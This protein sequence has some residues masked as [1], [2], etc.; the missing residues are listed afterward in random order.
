MT[1][2]RDLPL[3]RLQFYATAAYTCS[4]LP[5]QEARSQVV[6]PG[7]LVDQILYSHLVENGFR[8][9]GSFTYR[10]HCDHCRACTPVRV[11]VAGFK[12]NRSQRRTW[13][14]HQHLTTHQLPLHFNKA[15]FELYVRYQNARHPE[16]EAAGDSQDQYEHFLLQSSVTSYL[17]E[18]RENGI[19]RMVSVIDEL[20]QGLSSVYTFY[21][22]HQ[23][24]ASYGT[25][26]ILWQVQ[27]CKE[28]GLA[29]LYLGYWIAESKK[30][31]YKIQFQPLQGLI[32]QQWTPLPL[33]V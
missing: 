9:S 10:P 30:M 26:N 24:R 3:H 6:T 7:Y 19:L 2:L 1:N 20:V 22:P 29:W 12:P 33:P 25:Y 8:R 21:D 18:F 27:R 16:G 17:V 11:D 28:L 13:I 23:P 15:H 32:H 31:A 5:Q 14:R 4:Y